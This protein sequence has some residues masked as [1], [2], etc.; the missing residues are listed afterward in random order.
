[1]N[2]ERASK[3]LFSND[4]TTRAVR[5]R[6]LVLKKK[7]EQ[8]KKEEKL[9]SLQAQINK[10]SQQQKQIENNN[11]NN[12]NTNN[13]NNNN[14]NNDEQP[15]DENMEIAF[16]S[17]PWNSEEIELMKSLLI[18]SEWKEGWNDERASKALFP[19]KSISEICVKRFEL[20]E[21]DDELKIEEK[22][23]VVKKEEKYYYDV[24][25]SF[26]VGQKRPNDD[27]STIVN[28]KQKSLPVVIDLLD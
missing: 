13:N 1:M 7:S 19:N 20:G 4:R 25:S 24:E 26:K 8:E 18:G 14:N 2:D 3:E 9:K 12:N 6:R 28:K 22:V 11:N 21:E 15:E 17:T 16:E 23:T 10:Q 5:D 27:S